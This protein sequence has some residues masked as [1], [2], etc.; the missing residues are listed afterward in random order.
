[1]F[2][3]TITDDSIPFASTLI[4]YDWSGYWPGIDLDLGIID[5]DNN[6]VGYSTGID[7]QETIAFAPDYIGKYNVAVDKWIG[8]GRY[9]LDISYK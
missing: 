1:M 5:N 6:Y 2:P 9:V 8:S 7:R 3:V 4:M